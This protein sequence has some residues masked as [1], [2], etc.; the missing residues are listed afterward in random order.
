MKIINFILLIFSAVFL[1]GCPKNDPEPKD[2]REPMKGV[3]ISFNRSY[4]GDKDMLEGVECGK[5][6][7]IQGIPLLIEKKTTD[8]NRCYYPTNKIVL[9]IGYGSQLTVDVSKYKDIKSI[10]IGVTHINPYDLSGK[11]EGSVVILYDINDK[12]IA[13]KLTGRVRGGND[14][15]PPTEFNEDLSHVRK[16]VIQSWAEVTDI[17][18]VQMY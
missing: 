6:F 3:N 10:R 1:F 17:S 12:I 7:E 11:H 16:V 9:R 14:N 13:Q 18:R 15:L 4:S 5:P 2:D 8:N